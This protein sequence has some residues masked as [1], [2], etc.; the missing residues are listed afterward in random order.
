MDCLGEVCDLR[1]LFGFFVCILSFQKVNVPRNFHNISSQIVYCFLC[2]D[3][4]N[5][6]IKSVSGVPFLLHIPYMIGTS[7]CSWPLQQW[8]V[9]IL[10]P[11]QQI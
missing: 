6:V 2:R 9:C 8:N 1:V 7:H 11:S 5:N 10:L 3:V 4:M